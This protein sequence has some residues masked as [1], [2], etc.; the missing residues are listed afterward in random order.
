MK[1]AAT[2]VTFSS[3]ASVSLSTSVALPP[4]RLKIAMT[5]AGLRA[6]K[7]A[8]GEGVGAGLAG[9]GAAAGAAGGAAFLGAGAAEAR[10]GIASRPTRKAM[11]LRNMAERYQTSPCGAS[12][13]CARR[14][15]G[16]RGVPIYR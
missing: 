6:S 1:F 16:F 14:L 8:T 12:M 10:A 7:L 2:E 13:A 5:L 3:T 4:A 9:A 11:G 15:G